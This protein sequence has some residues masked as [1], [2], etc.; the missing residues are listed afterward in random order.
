MQAY[1]KE[2]IIS[3][4]R[5]MNALQDKAVLIHSS[6]KA[7][8]NVEGGADGLL[9]AFIEYFTKEGGLLLIPTHTW[10]NVGKKITL[11]M[12][13]SD[14][15]LGVLSTVALNRKDGVRTENPTHSMVVFGDKK[16]VNEFIKDEHLIKSPTAPDSCY[17]KLYKERGYVLLVGVQHNKNTYLHCVDEMLQVK[18]R[19][20]EKTIATCILKPDGQ[21]INRDVL[22]YYTDY[23]DDISNRFVK[24]ELAFRYHRC[25]TDGFIGNAPT[26]LC[27]AE[28]MKE[29]VEF[30][31]KN[32]NGKDPL[33]NEEAIPQ[34]WYVDND[35]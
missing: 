25:I 10:H 8:G 6:L 11:D 34:G 1:S 5:G 22:F 15:C 18:N 20:T 29:T 30:I 13:S 31:Y 35:K 16:R 28:K 2:D 23:T 12:N 26:Q 9:N 7:V 4:L 17:G 27:D 14:N 3:Q 21:R 19:M 24:Y 32:S 33:S